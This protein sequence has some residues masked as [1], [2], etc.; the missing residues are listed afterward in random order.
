MNTRWIALLGIF[1]TQPVAANEALDVLEGRKRASDI[2]VPPVPPDAAA[3]PAVEAGTTYADPGWAAGPLDPLWARA[4]L[5]EDRSN[6]YIQRF[7]I[8]GL[9]E[10]RTAFGNADTDG[11]SAT[12]LDSSRARRARLGARMRAFYN[13]EVEAAVEF[14][15]ESRYRG[16]ERLSARTALSESAGVTFGKF[17]P[18]FTAEYAIE[19]EFLTTPDRSVLTNMIAPSR[20]LGV[21][22]D[23][24][25]NDVEY[26]IGWFSG[27]SH[28]DLPSIEGDGFLSINLGRSFT[29]GDGDSAMRSRWHLDY[30]H[31]FDA[32]RSGSI[33][34]YDVVG[35]TSANGSQL[36]M[37]NP[38]FRN[39]ISTGVTLESERFG[40]LG[41]F[42]LAKGDSA[43]WGVTLSPTWWVAPGLL[44]VVGRY[45]Y[46]SSDEPA[47]LV[48][49]M[50]VSGDPL[51]DSSPFFVGDVYH[52]FY[53]GGNLHLYQDRMVVMSG[54]ERTILNDDSGAGFNSNAW[55]W[56]AGARISF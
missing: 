46:A 29:E 13:T 39:M 56:H 17:R 48:T 5:F 12:D 28:S 23:H 26:A 2:N 22:F 21:R 19:S 41:D 24:R 53:L 10:Y 18:N 47:G 16:I 49:T 27:D 20:T 42:I 45:H 36:V 55:I 3:A 30:I 8:T 44:K 1:L 4:A 32:G 37:R 7:E 52:S 25:W 34:R 9:F 38:S 54:L 15:G 40:F 50:G 6:P 11:A 14:A 31:N 43:V 33:P 51:F 35:R